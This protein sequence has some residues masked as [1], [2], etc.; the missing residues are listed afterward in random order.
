MKNNTETILKKI[1][2][3]ADK[4]VEAEITLDNFGDMDPLSFKVKSRLSID[5]TVSF[6]NSFI[7][8]ATIEETFL[9]AL[10]EISFR[11]NVVKYLSDFDIDN[12]EISEEVM[13]GIDIIYSLIE[14]RIQ[15]TVN[16]LRTLCERECRD[17]SLI[18][19]AV[20][21]AT[22]GNPATEILDAISNILTDSESFVKGIDTEQLAGAIKKINDIKETDVLKAM[23][24]DKEEKDNG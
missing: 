10:F 14:T 9:D 15:N 2:K 7:E 16:I 21:I 19:A 23:V 11:I 18:Q 22:T 20:I 17:R 3:I 13:S 4:N 12:F 8:T 24:D 1:S 6:V 5:D